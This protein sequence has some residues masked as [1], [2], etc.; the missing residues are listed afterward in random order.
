MIVT[1]DR[2]E[3]HIKE[4]TPAA[5]KFVQSLKSKGIEFRFDFQF[6]NVIFS[7]NNKEYTISCHS[8]YRFSGMAVMMRHK[9]EHE[10]EAV[11]LPYEGWL[12]IILRPPIE[13]YLL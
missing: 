11:P 13:K 2:R 3:E 8:F 1:Y 9:G 4:C 10:I 7:K 12:N 5:Q 6:D